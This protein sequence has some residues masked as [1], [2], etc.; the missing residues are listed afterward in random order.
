MRKYEAMYIIKPDLEQEVTKELI[1]KFQ[2]IIT[3]NGGEIEKVTETGKRRLAYEIKDF[4]EGYYVLVNFQA[5]P[6]VILELERV[7]RITENIIR[8]LVIKDEK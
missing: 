7:F 1:Q 6:N 2:D 8:Y 3:D 4:K 5:E